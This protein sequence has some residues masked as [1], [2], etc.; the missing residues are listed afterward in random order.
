[1]G[2]VNKLS[3]HSSFFE[4][5]I[6]YSISVLDL[7]LIETMTEA[8]KKTTTQDNAEEAPQVTKQ[9]SSSPEKASDVTAEKSAAPKEDTPAEAE[10]EAGDNAGEPSKRQKVSETKT[11]ETGA[12]KEGE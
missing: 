7:T 1:M 12:K 2:C 6:Q 3:F 8:E 10:A 4:I 5:P 9:A 11:I